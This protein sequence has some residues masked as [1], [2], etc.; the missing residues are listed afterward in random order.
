MNLKDAVLPLSLGM[1]KT[2]IMAQL[3]WEKSASGLF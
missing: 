3:Q 2:I 1:Y